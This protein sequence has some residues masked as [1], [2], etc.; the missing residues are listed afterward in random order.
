M[1]RITGEHIGKAI[2]GFYEVAE[3][4]IK[5]CVGKCNDGAGNKQFQKQGAASFI[6]KKS[7][8]S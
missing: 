3:I 6:L 8:K 7:Q 2:L 1:H 4:D 5:T